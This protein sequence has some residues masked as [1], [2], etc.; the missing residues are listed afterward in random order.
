MY[1]K[2]VVYKHVEEAKVPPRA[3]AAISP[4]IMDTQRGT[5][6]FT[7]R[8]LTSIAASFMGQGYRDFL[9]RACE[10]SLKNCQT[11]HFDLI[12]NAKQHDYRVKR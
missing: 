11:D 2:N 7:N 4:M 9:R 8:M 6:S 10:S 5:S 1:H 12:I 3:I